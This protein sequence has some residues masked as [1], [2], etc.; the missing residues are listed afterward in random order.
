ML[1]V[2][3]PLL[4]EQIPEQVGGGGAFSAPRR[5]VPAV[6]PRVRVDIRYGP[7]RF[8][9]VAALPVALEAVTGESVLRQTIEL[10]LLTG[11][12]IGPPQTFATVTGAV[13]WIDEDA[14]LLMLAWEALR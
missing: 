1:L 13:E 6:V 4:E 8:R 2:L 5:P 12:T 3:W 10:G 14:E 11:A 9:A 7:G